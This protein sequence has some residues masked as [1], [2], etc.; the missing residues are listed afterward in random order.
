[1]T[2]RRINKKHR[3]VLQMVVLPGTSPWY[4]TPSRQSLN[5]SQEPAPEFEVRNEITEKLGEL[6]LWALHK[7]TAAKPFRGGHQRPGGKKADGSWAMLI[8]PSRMY[9]QR[10]HRRRICAA[11][12]KNPVQAEERRFN[13]MIFTYSFVLTAEHFMW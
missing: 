5:P 9:F 8:Q 4:Y 10:L 3:G 12:E 2:T 7:L 13:V 1:M 6:Y 11:Q